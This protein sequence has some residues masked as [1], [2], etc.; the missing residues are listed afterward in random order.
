MSDVRP[1]RWDLVPKVSRREHRLIE[2]FAAHWPHA[3]PGAPA[4]KSLAPLT[5]HVGP[6]VAYD[7]DLLRDRLSDPTAFALRLR[8]DDGAVGYAVVP[9]LVGA[10]CAAVVFGVSKARLSA[11]RAATRAEQGATAFAAAAMLERYGVE[12]VTVEPHP[13]PAAALPRRL[14]AGWTLAIEVRVDVAGVRGTAVIIAEEAIA[15]APPRPRATDS[16]VARGGVWLDGVTVAAPIVSGVGR[17][18]LRDLLSLSRRDVVL[19]DSSPQR[20]SG[21][22]AV[23]RGGF[24]VTLTEAEATIAGPY[25]RGPIMEQSV[26]DD[27]TVEVACQLG[28]LQLTA[29]RVLELAPGQVLPLDRRLGGPV[30]L[31]VGTRVIGTGE[32]V[33][34]DGELGIRV[35]ALSAVR[36]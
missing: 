30:E 3:V 22:L 16:S 2:A 1:Y 8:R 27:V 25:Q 29:R 32:L 17:V 19:L 15:I 24:P 10:D 34:V 9:G 36:Q 26:A 33:D 11:P 6:V 18:A 28:S 35:L 23:G 4:P 20:D 21:R 13:E 12:G 5:A 31:V 7:A 14:G